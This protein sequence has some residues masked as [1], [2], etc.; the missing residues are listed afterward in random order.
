MVPALPCSLGG[1]LGR[2]TPRNCIAWAGAH[3]RADLDLQEKVDEK[4]GVR[5]IIQVGAS[6]M[7]LQAILRE[8][9]ISMLYL[10]DFRL[11]APTWLWSSPRADI[12]GA[13]R[14]QSVCRT[15]R[16][17]WAASAVRYHQLRLA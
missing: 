2:R 14:A 6:T 11:A 5:R 4:Q 3:R 12:S 9:L 15:S 1:Y 10:G 8:M 17:K 7:A 13:Y 16:A